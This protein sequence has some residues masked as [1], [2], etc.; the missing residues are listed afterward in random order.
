MHVRCVVEP[1]APVGYSQNILV[2]P[3]YW[4]YGIKLNISIFG[5]KIVLHSVFL[6]T[7]I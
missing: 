5:L 1:V 7:T 6:F 3:W 2:L 4:Y